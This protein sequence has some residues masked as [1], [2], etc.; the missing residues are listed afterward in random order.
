M[1]IIVKLGYL[2]IK[3]DLKKG[4][5]LQHTKEKKIQKLKSQLLRAQARQSKTIVHTNKIN[6]I[7]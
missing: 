4:S 2:S 7:L 3:I 5:I 1:S 6:P